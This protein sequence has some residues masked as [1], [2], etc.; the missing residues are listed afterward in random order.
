MQKATE[1]VAL[2]GGIRRSEMDS[3][4][5]M[6]VLAKAPEPAGPEAL[7]PNLFFQ[8]WYCKPTLKVLVPLRSYITCMSMFVSAAVSAPNSFLPLAAMKLA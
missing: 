4:R 5:T 1:V 8:C 7:L 2:D 6:G 3:A